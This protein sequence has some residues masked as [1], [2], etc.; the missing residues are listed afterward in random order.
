MIISLPEI[1]LLALGLALGVAIGFYVGVVYTYEKKNKQ[2]DGFM[3]KIIQI[4]KEAS[5]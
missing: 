5:K 4:V 2:Y 3:N 1:V